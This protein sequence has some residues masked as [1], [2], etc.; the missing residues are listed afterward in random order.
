MDQNKIPTEKE[1][2]SSYTSQVLP[3]YASKLCGKLLKRFDLFEDREILK[4]EIKEL[5]YEHFRELKELIEAYGQGVEM[6]F[7]LFNKPQEN[8]EK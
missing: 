8:K 2:F 4:K 7:F 6:S 3:F 5:I 1:L